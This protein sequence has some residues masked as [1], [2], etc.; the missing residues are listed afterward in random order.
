MESA[1]S[2]SEGSPSRGAVLDQLE[3]LL[4]SR[5]FR[6]SK[7]YPAFLRYVVEHTL[8]G[9]M[10]ILKERTLGIEV[11]SR[12]SDYDSNAD[13]IVRVTAG[14]V[15][16]RIAQYYQE[17]GH[18]HEVRIELPLGG[19]VPHFY[20]HGGPVP[21]PGEHADTSSL[22]ALP[23]VVL[24]GDGV[25]A[26]L[27]APEVVLP[28]S[29]LVPAID[30]P[31][32]EGTQAHGVGDRRDGTGNPLCGACRMEFRAGTP[33]GDGSGY[34]LETGDELFPTRAER[35]RRSFAG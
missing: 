28:E 8:L 31:A 4:E 1:I 20:D 25:G 35:N 2:A 9:D 12:A 32:P 18:E 10:E 6:N 3:R 24:S 14:E 29:A 13:P 16:K 34:G 19:Y 30:Q 7:R 5:H 15:R 27:L 22:E 11:F 17:P 33:C 26:S 23:P 21:S